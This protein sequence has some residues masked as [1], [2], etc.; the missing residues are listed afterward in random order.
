MKKKKIIILLSLLL[1]FS[2]IVIVVILYSTNI[3]NTDLVKKQVIDFVYDEFHVNAVIE[4]NCDF[5]INNGYNIEIDKLI[6]K[7]IS[8]TISHV[9]IDN[10]TLLINEQRNNI[11]VN[12]KK[13]DIIRNGTSTNIMINN[14][15]DL[16]NIIL[17]YIEKVGTITKTG[18]KYKITSD[19][20]VIENSNDKSITKYYDSTLSLNDKI[21]L[22]TLLYE[23]K[24]PFLLGIDIIKKQGV[25]NTH[26]ISIRGVAN[27]EKHSLDHNSNINITDTDITFDSHIVLSSADNNNE[28]QS[29]N[30]V[31]NRIDDKLAISHKFNFKDLS[32]EGKSSLIY[33][34]NV[35]FIKN[36]IETYSGVTTQ[37]GDISITGI[38]VKNADLAIKSNTISGNFYTA[39]IGM[40]DLSPALNFFFDSYKYKR[41]NTVFL[42]DIQGSFV[43]E[44]EDLQYN[45]HYVGDISLMLDGD[46]HDEILTIKSYD[47]FDGNIELTSGFDNSVEKEENTLRLGGEFSN[48]D[49][50]NM[51]HTFKGQSKYVTQGSIFG[52]I[53]LES[54]EGLFNEIINSLSGEILLETDDLAISSELTSIFTTTLQQ[55]LSEMEEEDVETISKKLDNPSTDISCARSLFFVDKGFILSDHETI[56]VTEHTNVFLSGSYDLNSQ[57]LDIGIVPNTKAF[58]D[59]STSPFVKFFRVTGPL[60]NLSISLDSLELLKSGASTTISYF[61]GPLGSMAFDFLVDAA[62]T[63]IECNTF[64][65]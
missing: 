26:E 59:I 48:L 38:E 8:D 49:L 25:Q 17:S 19:V 15:T 43:L 56:F 31:L 34:D 55:T 35:S 60:S 18:K 32:I 24:Y 63:E 14:D 27:S 36:I 12:F 41:I 7:N 22:K 5:K 46:K 40:D 29:C 9:Y 42:R 54:R 13:A 20:I 53:G 6:L 28:K 50:Y 45:N 11:S 61:T 62:Q 44:I 21:D 23:E 30:I 37:N 2:P 3:E 16:S 33:K 57:L 4:G 64:L 1:L 65:Q 39:N 51:I 52:F 58:F 47:I 10:V